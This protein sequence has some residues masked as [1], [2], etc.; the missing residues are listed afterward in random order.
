MKNPVFPSLLTL[1]ALIATLISCNKTAGDPKEAA[2][3]LTAA[4]KWKIDEIRVN[5]KVT[6]EKGK[7]TQQFGGIDFR[8]YMEIVEIRKDGNFEGVFKGESTPFKLQWKLNENK[9]T[10]GLP[11]APPSP[12][13][14]TIAPADVDENSFIMKTQSTAYDY[15]N[16][17]KI[18]LKFKSLK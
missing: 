15:P 1:F 4:P 17:T 13:D 3:Y 9:I 8:R 14:W 5:D 11:G 6:F 2:A 12:G 18:A 16:V 7:M 10:V